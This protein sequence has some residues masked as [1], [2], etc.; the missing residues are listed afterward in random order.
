MKQTTALLAF[1]PALRRHLAAIAI[2]VAAVTMLPGLAEAQLVAVIVNGDPITNFDI[3]QRSKLIQLSTHKTPA[4]KDVIEELIDEKL[5]LQLL[6]R[7][8]IPDIDKD[9]ESAFRNM[10]RRMRTTPKQFTD[11][12]E[13]TGLRI[14]TLKSRMKAELIWNQII[15]G[16]YQSSFQ[17]SDKDIEA[18]IQAKNPHHKHDV[19]GRRFFFPALNAGHFQR[20]CANHL[21]KLSLGHGHRH[22]TVKTQLTKRRQRVGHNRVHRTS[23]QLHPLVAPQVSHFSQVPFRTMV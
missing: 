17:F 15:R 2:A 7:Y 6:K 18:R 5:K 11:Q 16:R 14:E 4:R 10:A 22:A 12:L 9:V 21:S 23:L 1:L 3:E 13:R 20:A 8:N 19:M